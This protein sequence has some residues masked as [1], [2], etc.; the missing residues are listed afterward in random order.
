[1]QQQ[2]K[3]IKQ[4]TTTNAF[5]HLNWINY[6]YLRKLL[7][8][9]EVIQIVLHHCRFRF[10]QRQWQQQQQQQNLSK[11]KITMDG[12]E[13]STFASYI[14]EI[15]LFKKENLNTNQIE[16]QR[17]RKKLAPRI[18]FGC[19]NSSS[20]IHIKVLGGTLPSKK[21]IIRRNNN[22]HRHRKSIKKCTITVYAI[23]ITAKERRCNLS[24]TRPYTE[25]T[26]TRIHTHP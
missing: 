13:T 9:R 8:I 20:S 1:M 26:Y 4:K 25:C 21:N 2:Q 14:P 7:W 6:E 12:K 5:T 22:T 15:F 17:G 3:P 18:T 11:S 16:F 23:H 24:M 19:Q 10:N